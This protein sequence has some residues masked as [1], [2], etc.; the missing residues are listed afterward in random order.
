MS[1]SKKSI[2]TE[3]DVARVAHLARLQ[4]DEHNLQIYAQSLTHIMEMITQINDK[5]TTGIIPMA[6]PIPDAV[7]RL[8]E[9]VVT[10]IPQREAYQRTAASV[11][12]GLYLVP[13][14]I[15]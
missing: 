12:S 8:R 11:E 4:L 9:D 7:M 10:D 1:A 15:E 2:V 3:R 13:Q 14:V 5:D 6:S